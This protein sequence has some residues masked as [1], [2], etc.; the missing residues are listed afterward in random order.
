MEENNKNNNIKE[1]AETTEQRYEK[2]SYWEVAWGQIKKNKVAVLGI[3]CIVLCVM[4]ALYAPFISMSRPFYYSVPEGYEIKNETIEALKN[5]LD[6]KKLET[7]TSVKTTQWQE[8]T[9]KNLKNLPSEIDASLLEPFLNRKISQEDLEVQLL[10]SGFAIPDIEKITNI[11]RNNKFTKESLKGLLSGLS[12]TDDEI[13]LVLSESPVKT[14]YPFFTSL[15]DRNYFKNGVDI[16]YNVLMVLSPLFLLVYFIVKLKMGK[17]FKY[18]QFRLVGLFAIIHI[19]TFL[20][21]SFTP[22]SYQPENYKKDIA[23]FKAIGVNVTSIFPLFDYMHDESE[24]TM[25]VRPP[26]GKHWLGTDKEGR[27]VFT[28]MVYGTR[29]SISIGVVAVSIYVCIGIFLGAMAG[30]FGGAVDMWI[31]RLIE[32]MICFP[33]FFLILTIVS[34]VEKKTIFHIMFIIGLTHWTGVARLVRAEF[35]KLRNMDYVQAAIALGLSKGRI[36]FGHVLPNAMAPVLVSAT[37]GVAAAILTE[38]SLSFLGLGDPSAPSWG[39][40]LNIGRLEGKIWLILSPG[41]AI[42]FIVSVFNLVGEALRDALDPR[43]RQ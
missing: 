13:N 3:W 19:I 39:E 27:D 24:T 15:F 14:C 26:S 10:E 1:N 23:E 36:M 40:M 22:R 6:S 16:F 42:F 11:T 20:I 33:S 7:L 5:K 21:I 28:R 8:I 18:I 43:L 31:T 41:I 25:S 4:V 34:F 35:L 30:Y 32:I 12:F 37:F 9:D 29:I 17:G 2:T 38:S